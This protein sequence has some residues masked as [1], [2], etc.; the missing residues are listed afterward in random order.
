MEEY[1]FFPTGEGGFVAAAVNLIAD[2][3]EETMAL[4]RSLAVP[5]SCRDVFAFL[6]VVSPFG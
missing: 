3:L 1:I 4:I 5:M 2:L 6:H